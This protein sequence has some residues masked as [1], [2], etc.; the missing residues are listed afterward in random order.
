MS[1]S[2]KRASGP[3]ERVDEADQQ[4]RAERRAEAV[5]GEPVEEL[6]EDQEDDRIDDDHDDGA[7][8]V[9]TGFELPSDAG[10]ASM[11]MENYPASPGGEGRP[12]AGPQRPAGAVVVQKHEPTLRGILRVVATVVASAA[13]LYL[14][15]LP[16]DADRLAR[17]RDLRRGIGG[18]PGQPA[19]AADARGAAI[20]LVYLV[21]VLIPILLGA[22]LVPPAVTAASDLVSDLPS[23]VSDL[24]DTVQSSETLQEP[25]RELRPGQ[26][27]RGRRQQRGRLAR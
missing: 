8:S 11:G 1:G 23:Y 27:A 16:A 7:P 12:A 4:R 15:Y 13:A 24:N 3:D 22:I 26:Q 9:S 10:L 20:A 17:H 14:I 25:E 21:L 2:A 5:E 18:G 6:G 19:R